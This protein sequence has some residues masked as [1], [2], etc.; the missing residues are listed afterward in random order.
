[1][2]R[3][4]ARVTR[5]IAPAVAVGA[6][7]VV[8][9]VAATRP[10][11]RAPTDGEARFAAAVFAARGGRIGDV[12][13]PFSDLLAARQLAAVTALVPSGL[14]SVWE[15][16]RAAALVLGVVTAM[17]LWPVLRRLGCG[18]LPTAVAVAVVGVTP[19]AVFLH[20][21]VTAAAVAVPWLLVAALLV[22]V[23]RARA[24]GA[25][26][27]AALAVLTAPL[28]GA[29]LLALA[30]HWVADPTVSM[31]RDR[32]RRFALALPLGAAT[33]AVAVSA[34]GGGTL[35]GVAAVPVST[36]A[37]VAGAVGGL[38]VVALGWHV[39]WLR[40]LLTPAVL[41]L[42]VLLVPGP[43]R[44]AAALA[45]LPLLALVG[46]ALADHAAVRLPAGRRAVV[47]PVAAVASVVL[48]VAAAGGLAPLRGP[49]PEP[50][51]ASLLTWIDVQ[52]AP[53]ATVH[54]DA[55]DRAELVAAGFPPG[56]LRGPGDPAG[57]TDAML[58]GARPG[59]AVPCPAL[60][61]IL[62]R[63][64]GAPAEICAADPRAASGA[65]EEPSRIRV[66]T[67]LAANPALRLAPAAADLL[68]TGR[69]DPRVLIALGAMSGAHT[70]AVADFPQAA[71]EPPDTLRR[72]V[73]ITSVDD[74]AVTGNAAEPLRSWFGAQR[75][76]FA[77]AEVRVEGAG[78]R[79]GYRMPSPSGLLPQ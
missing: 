40:P 50:T 5:S 28:L 77:P 23:D 39:R 30:A 10:D 47:W 7:L 38:V 60:L 6:T 17:L 72:A 33:V 26:V 79:V 54:A 46:A 59:S 25:T 37:V 76:P 4:F 12:P 75:P 18:P 63:W 32:P 62:P 56:R 11:G 74:A 2:S 68:T 51:A 49:D 67:A 16:V 27:A 69:V 53:G 31:L 70:L 48:T 19:P 58:V 71:F 44:G 73:L 36:P 61:A 8:A 65:E 55:L 9:L 24:V 21:G 29:V 78:L 13:L 20:T 41:L 22:A 43:G 35:A 45:A 66:G 34:S 15:T 42:A 3:G 52:L 57:G 64:R 14:G 1:V